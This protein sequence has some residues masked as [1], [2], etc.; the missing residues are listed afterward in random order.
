L[1]SREE[2]LDLENYVEY[3]FVDVDQRVALERVRHLYR[4]EEWGDVRFSEL[5]GDCR[6]F[7]GPHLDPT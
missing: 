7:K 1:A 5:Q 6:S 3:R 2:D 4:D